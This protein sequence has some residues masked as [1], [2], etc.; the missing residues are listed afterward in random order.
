[1]KT[2][3]WGHACFTVEVRGKK[4][5]F[6]PFITPNPLAAGIDIES[7]EADYIL[8]SHGHEDHVA[9]AIYLAKKTGAKVICNW[10]LFVW[11]GK[12]GVENAHPMNT[13]GS[14]HFDFGTVKCTVAQHSS[15]LPDGTY[16]GNPMGFVIS[17]DTESFY[18]A[19]DTALTLDMQLISATKPSLQLALLPIGG[20]FTMDVNDAIKASD[21]IQC[22]RVIGLHFDTF[23]YIK[24]DREKAIQSFNENNKELILLNI[25]ES[26]TI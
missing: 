24:I 6:D 1:M 5:L 7:I 17:T 19:G 11:L 4:L 9:D 10:E 26:I 25:G 3:Y 22:K 20:N 21:F 23:G 18:Y 16:G 8:L 14:F 2:T 15:S 12:N 13:G